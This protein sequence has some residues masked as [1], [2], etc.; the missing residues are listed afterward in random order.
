[1]RNHT[2]FAQRRQATEDISLCEPL[3]RLDS[4]R[5]LLKLQVLCVG[6]ARAPAAA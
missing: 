1:M 4:L 6:H 5:E 2:P 3:L